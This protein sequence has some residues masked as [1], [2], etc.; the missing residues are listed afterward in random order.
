V[1]YSLG[2]D[3]GTTYTAAAIVEAGQVKVAD[4]G[5]RAPVIPSVLFVNEDGSVL[6]G[7][8]ANRRA[9]SDPSRVAREFKR[10][11]GDPTAILLGGSP[12]SAE[13][14]MGRLLR[15]TVDT[16]A[17]AQGSAPDKVALCRPANL[18]PYKQDL[19]RE[20]IRIAEVEVDVQLTE[21]EAAAG[22]YAATEHV[23]PD[24]V[25]AVYDLGG[26]TFD[27]AVLRSAT[28]GF[29]I[30]GEPEGI[31]RLGGIDF[32]QAVFGFVADAVGQAVGEL[33]ANDPTVLTAIARLRQECVEAKE[34]LSADTETVIPVLLPSLQTEIRITR[35]EFEAM[36]R[37]QVSDTI[38][39][40]R[41]ALRSAHVAPEEVGAVLLVGGSSRIPLVAELVGHELGRPV[42]VDA[43]PKHAVAKGAAL[44]AAG[45]ARAVTE[46][47]VSDAAAAP[48]AGNGSGDA[49]AMSGN[50]DGHR[51]GGDTGERERVAVGLVGREAPATAPDATPA[52]TPATPPATTS[53]IT[54]ATGTPSEPAA[55]EPDAAPASRR[56]AA[57][58]VSTPAPAHG[59]APVGD[60]AAPAPVGLAAA[61]AAPAAPPHRPREGRRTDERPGP[62]W[63][64]RP[65][66]IA[67]GV[68]VVAAIALVA[69]LATGGHGGGSA[70][71]G[72]VTACPAAGSPAVCIQ[73]VRIDGTNILADFTSHDVSLAGPDNGAF[74]AGSF[75]PVFFFASAG[76]TAGRVWGP[77]SPFGDPAS[78]LQ[79]FSTSDATGTTPTLCVLIQDATGGVFQGT[80][81]CAPLR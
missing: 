39:A 2:I 29:A 66:F 61:V 53:A 10:R 34:A 27:A 26:G 5:T 69:T 62:P 42:A 57:A 8:A 60:E 35:A 20:A 38:A 68:I 33:D 17:S 23:P 31:E 37:P 21:P 12:W 3:L 70:A 74:A 22:S 19:L 16:V 44:A 45:A 71:A 47:R 72:G 15:W 32:D 54:P 1:P 24:T 80:G 25:V 7:D 81:N 41:R 4:L 77:S 43:H 9:L 11:V 46:R 18:G 52:T 67:A 79:G 51:N 59:P 13:A 50:G 58:D 76:P 14:L 48:V 64:R 78:P 30:L 73:R 56:S 40:L 63:Y 6:V 36:I 55:T 75:H 65:L 28:D 49:G